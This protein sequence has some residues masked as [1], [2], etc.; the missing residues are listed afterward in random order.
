MAEDSLFAGID[1]GSTA[2]RIA[3]GQR[4][5]A[6]DKE[7]VHIVGAAEVPSAAAAL[8]GRTPSAAAVREA[9]RAARRKVECHGDH[10]ASA[11]YRSELVEALTARALAQ[12]FA[13]E[14]PR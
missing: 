12:A 4:L 6:G 3:V 1:I 9:A 11:E 7:T 8:I 2:V 10:H 14:L 13:L 5:P